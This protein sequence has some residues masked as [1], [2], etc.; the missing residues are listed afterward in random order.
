VGALRALLPPV[1]FPD[2][3]EAAMGRIPS[4]GEDTDE[5]LGELGVT[6]AELEALRAD[7]VV[8]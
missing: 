8:A 3:P 5:V 2:G 4:L 7:G 1:T 6:S